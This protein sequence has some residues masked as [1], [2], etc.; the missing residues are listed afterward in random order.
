MSAVDREQEIAARNVARP[1]GIAGDVF[2]GLRPATDAER[3]A[4]GRG[5]VEGDGVLV[6]G[7]TVEQR[8][9]LADIIEAIGAVDRAFPIEEGVYLEQ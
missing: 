5:Y 4:A 6:I 9:A 1:A 8:Q 2:V 3:E 7:G